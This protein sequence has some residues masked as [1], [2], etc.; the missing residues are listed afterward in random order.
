MSKY[1]S[2]FINKGQGG[3]GS[4][5]VVAPTDKKNKIVSV[6]GGGIHPTAARIAELTG[7]EARDG[8][9]ESVPDE[10]IACVII[11]C[12][13]TARIGVYPMKNILTVDILAS[14]P[15][16]PLSKHINENNFV[17]GVR[18][19]DVELIDDDDERFRKDEDN[20]LNSSNEINSNE[21]KK[22]EEKIDVSAAEPSRDSIILRFSKGIGKVMGI[23]YQAGR[24]TIETVI[25]NILPFMA[26]IS[27]LI[28]IINFSGL[29]DIIA[30]LIA[31]LSNSIL[32]FVIIAL[33]A[34]LPFL[35]PIL[36]P[37]AVI[38]Q[39]V[40]VLIG[41]QIA[42]GALPVAYAL[43]ALFA[44]NAQA[45]MDFI[46]VGLSLGEAEAETVE[47]GVPSILYSRLITGV[48]SV[49]I[50]WLLSVGMY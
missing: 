28:G 36:G 47:I 45:G 25:K 13:G 41:S 7:A 19:K 42:S 32:G 14:A 2:V 39:V 3:W 37:G 33:I 34:S 29:G 43:P 12:G 24:D 11:D 35:S 48:L 4:G 26:F 27:M 44:I 8:F 50:G 18:P 46:P 15:S 10:E 40:G 49:L 9:R 23:F 17:S 6:T 38:A 22:N 30:N 1:K 20:I 31:P 5:F 21:P 16:G